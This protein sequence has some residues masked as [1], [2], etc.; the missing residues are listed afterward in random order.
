MKA[1]DC[2]TEKI[3]DVA[4]PDYLPDEDTVKSDL[5]DYAFE[6]EWFDLH[7]GLMLDQLQQRGE[8]DNTLVMVTSDNGM[9]FPR[10]KGQMYEDDFHLPMAACWKNEVAGGRIIDDLISFI[11]IAPTLLELADMAVHPQM[12]GRSFLD[13]LKSGRSGQLDE[14]RN[15]VYMGRERHDMGREGDVGYPVR[16]IRTRKYLYIR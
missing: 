13:L 15:K 2:G 9:P 12:A 3:E 16:C 6:V 8:L 14:N 4:V 10:V 7:L 5:L 1:K 11:D